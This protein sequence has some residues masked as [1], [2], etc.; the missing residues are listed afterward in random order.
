VAAAKIMA[1]K[2]AYLYCLVS[3]PALPA[4]MLYFAPNAVAYS[5]LSRFFCKLI[6]LEQFTFL[7]NDL[8]IDTIRNKFITKEL[9]RNVLNTI[10]KE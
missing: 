4:R 2:V 10:I 5:H 1:D 8:L 3:L 9:F 7:I 6:C